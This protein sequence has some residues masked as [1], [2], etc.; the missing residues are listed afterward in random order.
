[1]SVYQHV[2]RGG[3]GPKPEGSRRRPQHR[4]RE[5][6]NPLQPGMESGRRGPGLSA[7]SPPRANQAGDS[8][9][10][11][12]RRHRRGY[13]QR[14]HEQE[15][16]TGRTRRNRNGRRRG[17]YFGY[18]ERTQTKPQTRGMKSI[19]EKVLSAND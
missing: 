2:G 3:I 13:N 16:G 1:R 19:V 5:S 7:G 18:F 12:L 11:V 8:P 6:R 9:P 15:T 14:P 10:P 4:R 17:R